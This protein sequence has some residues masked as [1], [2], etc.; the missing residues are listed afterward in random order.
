MSPELRV[1]IDGIASSSASVLPLVVFAV[2]DC[3]DTDQEKMAAHAQ[4]QGEVAADN[5]VRSIQGRPLRKYK[6]SE[7]NSSL[8]NP[9]DDTH[10]HTDVK[11]KER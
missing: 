6:P 5:V 11:K 2:G 4:T 10:T 3:C 9:L 7:V 1:D 8:L